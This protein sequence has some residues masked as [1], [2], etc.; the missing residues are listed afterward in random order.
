MADASIENVDKV[1]DRIT[2]AVEK[3]QIQITE[4]E[5]YRPDPELDEYGNIVKTYDLI[6]IPHSLNSGK[7]G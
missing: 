5:N 3:K 6:K 7:N 2:K 1:L 4:I